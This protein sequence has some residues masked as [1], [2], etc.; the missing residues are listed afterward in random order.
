MP[1]IKSRL[2]AGTSPIAEVIASAGVAG[3]HGGSGGAVIVERNVSA[4]RAI[5][6]PIA[7]ESSSLA[8]VRYVTVAVCL[9]GLGFLGALAIWSS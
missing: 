3:A 6:L 5:A 8:A 7:P 9:F 2:A 4:A 1:A